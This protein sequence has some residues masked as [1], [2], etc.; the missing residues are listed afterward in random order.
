MKNGIL[1]E[2]LGNLNMGITLY[3]AR[4]NLKRNIFRTLIMVLSVTLA[5][6][7]LFGAVVLA[8]GVQD[9]LNIVHQRLG[10]DLIIVPKGE[11]NNAKGALIS[12]TPTIFFMDKSVEQDIVKVSGVQATSPQVFLRS[13]D[14][15]CCISLVHMVGYKPETDFTIKPWL[16]NNMKGPLEPNEIIVG[17]KVITSVVG[18]PTKA[19]GQTLVFLGKPLT[20][21]GILDP[22]G[23]GTDFTVFMPMDTALKLAQGSPLYPVPVKPDQ[24]SA[25]LVKVA[26]GQT[27]ASV[28]KN[29]RNSV[30]GVEVITAADLTQTL[31]QD[32]SRLANGLG[33]VGGTLGI[34]ALLLV[35]ILF[36]LSIQQRMR[37]FGLFGAMGASRNYVFR[38]IIAESALIT[39]SGGIVGL[40]ISGLG[41]YLSRGILTKVMGNIYI[42]PRISYFAWAIA[43][44]LVVTVLMGVLGGLYAAIRLSRLEPMEAIRGGK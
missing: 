13:L 2:G 41:I 44:G 12:G 40:L 27:P 31:G 22:T 3:L 28:A 10:A 34:V 33:I 6:G 20:V 24:I 15:P 43:V 29:I 7:T 4:Q 39:G 1:Q 8:R 30:P 5:S 23:L 25:V 16:L 32:L 18:V 9:T 19:I 42:W 36:T 11:L 26:S 17:A 35:G 38:L 21:K 14:S 37:E